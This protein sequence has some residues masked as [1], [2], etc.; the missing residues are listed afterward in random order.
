MEQKKAEY[1]SAKRSRKLIREAFL[2]LMKEKDVNKIT[3]ADVVKKAD[4]NRSTFYAHYLDIPDVIET[5]EEEI[6]ARMHGIL[7]AF[8]FRSFLKDPLPVLSKINHYLEEDIDFY[9]TLILYKSSTG[10]FDKFA[11]TFL[12]FIK[13]DKDIPENIRH[14]VTFCV[15]VQLFAGGMMRMY[16]AWFKG[17]LDCTLDDIAKEMACIIIKTSKDLEA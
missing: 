2:S 12:D 15:R 16:E 1:K 14:S 9:R 7:S 13:E 11:K 8:T 3:V 4:I 10:F 17:E 5:F 6:F